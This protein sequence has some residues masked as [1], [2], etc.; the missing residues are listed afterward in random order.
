MQSQKSAIEVI[1]CSKRYKYLLALNNINLQ[2]NNNEIIG[3]IGPNGAGKTTLLNIIAGIVKPSKGAVLYNGGINFSG[4]NSEL[5][6][7]IV[8]YSYKSFLYDNLTGLENLEFWSKLYNN[9]KFLDNKKIKQKII[10]LA[11]SNGMKNW[12]DRPIHELST[13]MRKKIEFL[14][15][16]LVNPEIVLLDEPFSGMD[17]KNIELFI[18]LIRELNCTI[19]I[20]S[21]NLKTLLEVCN[22][23]IILKNG[24]IIDKLNIRDIELNNIDV[25]SKLKEFFNDNSN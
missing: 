19:C 6:R 5:R 23:I 20:V 24:K 18:K 7:L 12:L 25:E 14:R 22:K 10:E 17:P 2:V 21:H 11:S 8:L 1:N 15:I 4:K 16:L 3:I 13:G 9:H